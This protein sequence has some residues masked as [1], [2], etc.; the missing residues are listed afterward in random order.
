MTCAWT[1]WEDITGKYKTDIFDLYGGTGL[2]RRNWNVFLKIHLA[3]IFSGFI[4]KKR[5]RKIKG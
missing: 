2:N 1:A 4:I 3:V 5:K